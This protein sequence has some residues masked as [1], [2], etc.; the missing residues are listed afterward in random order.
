MFQFALRR[1]ANLD[2]ISIKLEECLHFLDKFLEGHDWVA[3][4]S[5]SIADCAIVATLM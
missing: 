5:I 4:N 2:D 1:G 3:G